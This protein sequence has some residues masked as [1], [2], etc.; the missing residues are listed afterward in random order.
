MHA[1][2]SAKWH[3]TL[4]AVKCLIYGFC[5]SFTNYIVCYKK[6]HCFSFYFGLNLFHI[7]ES[8]FNKIIRNTRACMQ[9]YSIYKFYTYENREKLKKNNFCR[10]FINDILCIMYKCAISYERHERNS[11]DFLHTV[12]KPSSSIKV[13][14]NYQLSFLLRQ[15]T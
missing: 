5:E 12:L 3:F 2:Y 1:L 13:I 15:F 9:Y 4:A 10:A 11:N 8:T 6:V 14:S 7:L